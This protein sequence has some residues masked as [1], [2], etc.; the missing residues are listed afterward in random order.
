M[1]KS[2]VSIQKQKQNKKKIVAL[3]AYDYSTAKMLDEAGVDI[4]LVGD[5]LAMV[6]LGHP[7]TLSI[8]VDEMLHHTKAVTNGVISSLVVADMPFM[9]Y[10][11]DRIEAV[12]NAGRFIKE[13][14]AK[15]VKLEGG[16]PNIID[17]VKAIIDCGI[18]VLGHL[19]FTP[20]HINNFGGYY[21]QANTAQ[22]GKLLLDQAK[23]LEKAGAFAV[24]LEM[25]P[26]PTGKFVTENINIPT[27]GIGAGPYC[28]G[29]ILVTDDLLGKYS[30]FTPSFVRKY[31]QI[32]DITKEAVTNFLDDVRKVNFPDETR[33][34]F[35]INVEEELKLNLITK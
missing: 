1:E 6:A 20:Q 29:Q 15:A 25:I 10:Q 18:P 13:G 24:V 9:S 14:K 26:S 12:K 35:K 21:I 23:E 34:S 33:E 31:A 17:T 8:T 16:S 7:N 22:K 19:G 28:D 3:T 27:I 30:N 4:I 11:A 32:S 5:S 2:I